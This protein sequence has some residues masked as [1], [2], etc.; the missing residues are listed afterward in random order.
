[1]TFGEYR[2]RAAFGFLPLGN[3]DIVA[4]TVPRL[5]NPTGEQKSAE[6][7]LAASKYNLTFTICYSII[8]VL[9]VQ[10]MVFIS[11]A[12]RNFITRVELRG[13]QTDENPT[14]L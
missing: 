3:T 9:E 5:G 1:M 13:F 10:E 14:D 4:F 7:R 2:H 6:G 12:D 11:H 8:V